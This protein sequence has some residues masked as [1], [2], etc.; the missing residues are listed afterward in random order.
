MALKGAD[1][2]IVPGTGL[3][4]D[5]FGLFRWGPYNVLKWSLAAKVRRCKLLFVSVG[6]GPLYGA[7]GRR[8]V[9]RP[10]PWQTSGPIETMQQ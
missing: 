8:L 2:L 5:A 10:F 9:N 1:T 6:A 4:S 7:L 3:L